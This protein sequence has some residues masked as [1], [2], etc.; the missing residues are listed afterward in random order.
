MNCWYPVGRVQCAECLSDK[1]KN[2]M[3]KKEKEERKEKGKRRRKGRGWGGGGTSSSSWELFLISQVL[4]TIHTIFTCSGSTE[5][6][7]TVLEVNDWNSGE[8]TSH[9]EA[10]VQRA[11]FQPQRLPLPLSPKSN[12]ISEIA[13]NLAYLQTDIKVLKAQISS[14]A[15]PQKEGR[16]S[17][18]PRTTSVSPPI[19]NV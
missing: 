12:P 6:F 14:G 11:S 8:P 15:K 19:L 7:N 9:N 4:R 17:I 16:I 18:F 5:L 13:P 2:Y 1:V 3:K 10:D